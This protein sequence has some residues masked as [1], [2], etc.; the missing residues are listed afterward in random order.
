MTTAG[1]L[2]VGGSGG[3]PGRQ[4]V[5]SNG[6]VLTVVS[7]VPAWAAQRA[8][9]FSASAPASP[10]VGDEWIDA[11]TGIRYEWIDDGTSTQWVEF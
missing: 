3:A 7:G 11:N 1:D 5:G 9:T 4:G 2:I 8:F 6:Q 10:G